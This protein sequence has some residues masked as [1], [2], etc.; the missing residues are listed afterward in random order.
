MRVLFV[1]FVVAIAG[2]VWATVAA[3]RH[4]RRT[5]VRSQ[6]RPTDGGPRGSSLH[7]S[8]DVV[9]TQPMSEHQQKHSLRQ[10]LQVY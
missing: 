2:L 10:Q 9:S 8:Q 3:S 6:S 4:I 1:T 5:R 7:L